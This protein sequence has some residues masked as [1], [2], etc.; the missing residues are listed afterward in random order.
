MGLFVQCYHWTVSSLSRPLSLAIVDVD[1]STHRNGSGKS[2]ILDSICF[3][4]GIT[5]MTTVSLTL[6]SA[7][8]KQML[9][10]MKLAGSRAKLVGLDLQ[11]RTSRSDE[12]FSHYRI[13]QL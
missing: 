3:V 10:A 4:L 5:N 8:T 7:R 9:R 6:H 13:R 11:T 2:N 12:G 1:R